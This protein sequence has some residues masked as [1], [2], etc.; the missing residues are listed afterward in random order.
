MRDLPVRPAGALRVLHAA[1][2]RR[3]R[4]LLELRRAARRRPR[5]AAR[6][7]RHAARR[8][9]RAG[10]RSTPRRPTSARRGCGRSCAR[11]PSGRW[12]APAGVAPAVA[13]AQRA[14]GDRAQRGARDLGGRRRAPTPTSSSATA[15]R[16]RGSSAGHRCSSGPTAPRRTARHH[17]D[18]ARAARPERVLGR[19]HGDLG[20]AGAGARAGH[21]GRAR[22]GRDRRPPGRAEL[23]GARGRQGAGSRAGATTSRA[24]ISPDPDGYVDRKVQA[25]ATYEYT[26]T[27]DGVE[28]SERSAHGDRPDRRAGAAA[29]RRAPAVSELVVRRRGDGRVEATWTWPEGTTEVVRRVG[30]DAARRARPAR[31]PDVRSPTPAT[32]S[33]AARRSTACRR[34]R[35]SRSSPGPAR[36]RE[37]WSGASTL[38]RQ[39]VGWSREF[40]PTRG[41]GRRPA[42][43]ARRAPGARRA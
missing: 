39:R 3:P 14:D 25:G 4:A 22:P 38:R 18:R 13:A 11:I 34:A 10:R 20:R 36:R 33:T 7:P 2:R 35:I 28:G 15:R 29:D 1:R 41:H 26:V 17:L 19:G 43:R 40:Q 30:P 27:L 32:R 5:A 24:R 21:A 37:L 16:A 31:P 23:D 42:E 6:P 9:R 8:D 12:R